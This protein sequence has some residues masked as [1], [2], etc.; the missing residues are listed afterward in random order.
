[1]KTI[2]IDFERADHKHVT[3]TRHRFRGQF[4]EA[5]VKFCAYKGYFDDVFSQ[6]QIASARKG[7]LPSGL[8]VHH[9]TPIGGGGNN[10]FNNLCVISKKFHSF[11]NKNYFDCALRG[12]ESKPVGYKR[13]ITVPYLPIVA[14]KYEKAIVAETL[15]RK[16]GNDYEI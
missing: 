8:T 11:L 3:S 14:L 15:M 16:K 13:K 9:I 1:M 10:D 5:F 4:R 6:E 12:L 2:T 7:K